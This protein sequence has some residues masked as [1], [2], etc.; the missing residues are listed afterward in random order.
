M[1][2]ERVGALALRRPASGSPARKQRD[3]RE[4]REGTGERERGE[5]ERKRKRARV[6]TASLSLSLS[7]FLSLSLSLSPLPPEHNTLQLKNI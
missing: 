2:R 1:L 5:G 3:Y 7:L 6:Y 4:G